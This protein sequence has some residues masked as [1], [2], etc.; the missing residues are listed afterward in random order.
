M[1]GFDLWPDV[2]RAESVTSGQV[3]TCARPLS[4]T[5]AE[6]PFPLSLSFS[7]SLRWLVYFSFDLTFYFYF[8]LVFLHLFRNIKKKAKRFQN[9]R[10]S[11]WTV[12]LF[13]PVSDIRSHVLSLAVFILLIVRY[14]C[15]VER[16]LSL[17][18]SLSPSVLHCLVLRVR[19]SLFSWI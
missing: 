17:C 15:V 4:T 5:S 1:R 2:W 9:G 12:D 13:R 10:W 8:S 7:L 18:L 14:V 6:P 16:V 19:K 3:A 11:F